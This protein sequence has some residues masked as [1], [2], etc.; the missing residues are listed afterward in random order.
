MIE[1]DIRLIGSHFVLERVHFVLE[2]V[3]FV[4][5]DRV[6]VVDNSQPPVANQ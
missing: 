1:L 4:E 6:A 2:L 3:S 5:L